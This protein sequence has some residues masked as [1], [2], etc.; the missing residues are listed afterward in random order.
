ML[1]T[2][3]GGNYLACAASIAVLDVIKDENLM[4]N[5]AELGQFW[6]RALAE[7]SEITA[8]RGRGLIIGFDLPSNLGGLRKDLLFKHHIFTGESKPNTIRL[9]PSLALKRDD[10]EILLDALAVELKQSVNS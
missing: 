9:L 7:F 2:T 10:A 4:A 8:I 1:G 5:A 3:F 6:L